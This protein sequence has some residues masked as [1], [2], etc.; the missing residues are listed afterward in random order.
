MAVAARRQLPELESWSRTD[1]AGQA[2]SS[3]Q[4]RELVDDP[5]ARLT[6]VKDERPAVVDQ[7]SAML[8]RITEP[9]PP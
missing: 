4:K 9:E 1:S 3:N 2:Q 6:G 8:A 7:I 5:R